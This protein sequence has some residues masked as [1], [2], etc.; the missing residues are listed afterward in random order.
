MD[1]SWG[2]DHEID[3]KVDGLTWE[4]RWTFVL[5]PTVTCT[6]RMTAADAIE[7]GRVLADARSGLDRVRGQGSAASRRRAL[8]A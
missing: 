4:G 1:G 5:D 6:A 8:D 2:I 7:L 3:M